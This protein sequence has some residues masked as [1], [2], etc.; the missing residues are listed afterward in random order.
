[1]WVHREKM[2]A[3]MWFVKEAGGAKTTKYATMESV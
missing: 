3:N 1:M 2:L